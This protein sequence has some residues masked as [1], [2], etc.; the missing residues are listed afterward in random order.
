MSIIAGAAGMPV[1]NLRYYDFRYPN[2]TDL[3]LIAEDEDNGREFTCD[4]TV[5]LWLLGAQLGRL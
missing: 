4:A 3:L 2:A 1:S 5:E